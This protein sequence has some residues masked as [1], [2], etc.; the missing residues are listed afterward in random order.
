MG[1]D[2]HGARYDPWEETFMGVHV[3]GTRCQGLDVNE[4]KYHGSDCHG[5][6]SHVVLGL[7]F[8]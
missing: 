8:K 5:A 3:C 1:L 6:S 4:G 7:I 2:V